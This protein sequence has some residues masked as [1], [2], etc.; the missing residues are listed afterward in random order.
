VGCAYLAAGL[1]IQLDMRGTGDFRTTLAQAAGTLV[2]ALV[3]AALALLP[4][5]GARPRPAA[6][7]RPLWL[8]PSAFVLSSLFLAA[9]ES[10]LGVA[11]SL[12]L[13]LVSAELL[14]R[15]AGRVGWGRRHEL[16]V[17]AGLLATYAWAAQVVTA[18][19]PD[20]RPG[21]AAGAVLVAVA[22]GAVLALAVR[23]TGR[24]PSAAAR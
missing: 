14:A 20:S 4:L 11:C 23:R 9:A 13:L 6:A 7:P 1:L 22:V 2:V 19:R 12:L 24:S 17:V 21:D 16:A 8:V 15:V 5:D 18:L 3:L 10:W